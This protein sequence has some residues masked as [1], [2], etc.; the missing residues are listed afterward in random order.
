MLIVKLDDVSSK[1]ST[2]NSKASGIGCA[3]VCE[4][5]EAIYDNVSRVACASARLTYADVC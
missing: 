4:T 5:V 3:Q 2:A 1:A